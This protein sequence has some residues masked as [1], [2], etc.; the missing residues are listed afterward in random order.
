MNPILFCMN[1]I[2]TCNKATLQTRL[3]GRIDSDRS[4]M[5]N[6][7]IDNLIMQIFRDNLVDRQIEGVISAKEKWSSHSL[8]IHVL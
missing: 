6:A 5:H 2:G 4:R 3:Y 8:Q 1:M 7:E